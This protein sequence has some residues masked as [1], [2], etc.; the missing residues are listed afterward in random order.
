MQ[1]FAR[2][3]DQLVLSTSDY[4]LLSVCAGQR[5]NG[6]LTLLVVNKSAS[7]ALNANITISGAAPGSTGN[8][9]SYGIP[10]DDAARTGIGSADIATTSV[11][12]LSTNFSF[13]FPAYSANV[14]A[15]GA[16]GAP[17]P[18]ASPTPTATKSATPTATATGTPIATSTSTP[19]TTATPTKTI[20]ATAT[21]TA[22]LVATATRTST[23]TATP[24]PMAIGTV[25]PS[26][27]SFQKQKVGTRSSAKTVTLSNSGT[28][29]LSVSSIST[30]A[31]FTQTNTCTSPLLPGKSCSIA[32]RFAPSVK[33]VINGS[34]KIN[35]NAVNTPQVVSLSGTGT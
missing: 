31:G 9:F 34:L 35:D 3:G 8:L 25:R 10:Q 21:S 4:S 13:N 24:T 23:P 32:V 29:S 18:T 28:A 26:S 27:L 16:S 33:G 7:N 5:T 17:S 12:G 6:I 20:T 15:F 1:H 11:A 22:T 30:S 2:G 14:I 19:T